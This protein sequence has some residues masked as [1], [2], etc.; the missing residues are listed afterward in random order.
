MLVNLK[1][2]EADSMFAA[3]ASV[4][5][6]FIQ[7]FENE[8]SD[9]FDVDLWVPNE[10]AMAALLAEYQRFLKLGAGSD[11]EGSLAQPLD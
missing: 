10:F 5:G 1:N 7:S 6:T 9:R 8:V 4:P 2:V 11:T 3:V